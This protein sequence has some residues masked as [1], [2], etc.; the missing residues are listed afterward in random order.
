MAYNKLSGTVIAPDYFGPGANETRINV[1][2]GNLSTSDGASIINVPRVS[3]PT[4]NSII[5]S[6]GATGN[7]LT[8]ETNLKFDG[9]KLDVAGNIS[10]SVNISASAFYGDGSNL[11]GV[12]STLAVKTGSTTVSNVSS[13]DMSFLGLV[14]NLGGGNVAITGSIGLPEDGS[15]TDGL[16]TEFTSKTPIG[17]AI[18]KFNEILKII[19]PS[20]APSLQVVSYQNPAG[21]SAKPSFGASNAVTGYTSVGVAAGFVPAIARNSIYSGSSV[22]SNYRIGVYDG[23]MNVTGT[24][25]YLTNYKYTNNVLNYASG[26]IANGE[27]GTLKLKL[28]GVDIHTVSLAGTDPG[29]G[30]PGSGSGNSLT[31]NSGFVSLSISASSFDGNGAEWY[32]FQHRTAKY[33]VAASDMKVGWNYAQVVHTVGS[34]DYATNYIEWINDPSG[35]VDDLKTINQRIEDVTL[36]GSKYLSGIQYNTNATAKYKVD[37]LNMYRNVYAAS[38]TPISFTVT[39]SSTPSAQSVSAIG[40]SDN[41]TKVLGVTASLDVN[42]NVDNLLSS[43]ITAKVTATHPLKATITNTGSAATADGFLVDNRTLSSVN[44]TEYFHDENFRK[45]SASYGTQTSVDAAASIWS[46]QNHMTGGG[47]AGHTDGLLLFN[48]RLYSPVD[49]DIPVGGN[50]A[51]M[52]NVSSGQPNY[53]GVSGTRT[54][55]RVLTNSSGAGIRDLKITSAK[56]G[57]A[58]SN[59]SLDA[60]EI[61]FFIKNPGSTDYMNIRNNFAYGSVGFNA[62]ALINGADDNS[63]TTGT[64]NS[65]HCVTFGTASVANGD[66]VVIKVEADES[67]GGYLSQITFQLGASDVSAPTEAPALDDID[68]NNSG[69]SDARLSFGAANAVSG[70]SNATGSAISLTDFNTNGLYSLSGDRRGVIGSLQNIT[71]ELNEDVAASSPNYAANSFKNAYTGSLVL[72]VNGA[73][74]HTVSLHNLNSVSDNFN[75]NN[76]GFSFSA[77]SFSETTD[78]IPDYT[79]PYRTGDYQVGTSDQ[80]LGWNYARVI[81]RVGASD[82]TTN[83]VEWVVDTDNNNLSSGSLSLSNFGH[84]SK[85]YQSGV[86]YFASRPTGSYIYSASNVYRNVYQDGTAISYPTTTNCAISN[87][88]I[89]GPGI[90]TTSSAASSLAL[91]F[92]NNSANCHTKDLQ[93]TGTVLLDAITSISG[94]LSLYTDRDVTV[95]SQILHPLKATLSTTALSKTAFMVYSGTIGS[96]TTSS[97]E[98]FGLETYRIVSGNYLSQSNVTSSG[99]S[100]NSTYSV[101][102]AGSYAEHADGLVSANGYLISPFQIGNAGDTRNVNNGGILQAPDNNPNYS[103]LTNATRSYYRHFVNDSGLAKSTFKLKLYGDANLISKAGAFNTGILATNKNITVE[104][105]VPFDPDFTGLDDTSTAWGD[106]IRPYSAGVQPTTDG[107]GILNLGGADLTQ[108]VG[109]SGREIP[110]QLQAS[111]ARSTQYFVVKVSA[112]KDWTGYLSRIDVDYT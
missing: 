65:V 76:S 94:G 34:T 67:W 71:G 108:T 19:A 16:F 31:N 79:K 101:N 83:Y 5:T 69:V 106:A 87:I 46:S 72:V 42:A 56:N 10:A 80:N 90:H 64:G 84:S 66:Y 44:L 60:D 28:N 92:L 112:H 25:N 73:E 93:V 43:S 98:H 48:Q 49:N 35:A 54:Y 33:K 75:S 8:C 17:T 82:T 36:V 23:T 105:K 74:V 11:S 99:N 57:T 22:G 81:H 89:A 59:T 9:S 102:D 29:S 61:R 18:D 7:S 39:N 50:I 96:T 111:Q 4:D 78:G 88:R 109:G 53:S 51:A 27:L 63:S 15:Y 52:S 77:L 1:I 40:G 3:N 86:G 110:L 6:V 58:Y 91:G 13:I 38:G 107:V 62:G 30:A 70:Y 37:L 12:G 20:P 68:A 104:V 32:T 21:V 95:S 47:A 2:S 103:S 26:A 100:W 24:L 14:Q 97:A 41:N 45:T 55:F 85:Y